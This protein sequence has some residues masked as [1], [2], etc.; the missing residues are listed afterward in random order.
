MMND[1]ICGLQRLVRRLSTF[2]WL[3]RDMMNIN[4]GGCTGRDPRHLLDV[5]M[6]EKVS[7]CNHFAFFLEET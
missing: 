5:F 3:E 4:F 2:L 7:S 1:C 6:L